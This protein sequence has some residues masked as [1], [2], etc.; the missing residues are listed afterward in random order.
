VDNQG[1]NH[2]NPPPK[3]AGGHVNPAQRILKKALSDA[4]LWYA[5]YDNTIKTSPFKDDLS[6]MEPGERAKFFENIA[7]YI[8]PAQK[9]VDVTTQG[10]PLERNLTVNFAIIPDAKE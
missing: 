2:P 4:W 10:Q 9:A 5:K 6:K 1:Q 7:K 8:I 3:K